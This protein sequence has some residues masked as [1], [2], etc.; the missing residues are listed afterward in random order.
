[1]TLDDDADGL[2]PVLNRRL[3]SELDD[4]VDEYLKDMSLEDII[5]VLEQKLE[6]LRS[7]EADHG[8]PI[9]AG[10]AAEGG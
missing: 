7:E 1:M 6:E 5:A 9:D 2:A 4:M 8:R 3:E 10:D